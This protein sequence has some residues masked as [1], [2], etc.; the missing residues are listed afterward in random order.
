MRGLHIESATHP[1]KA[2][3]YQIT[4]SFSSKWSHLIKNAANLLLQGI[5]SIKQ[6]LEITG[7]TVSFIC[8]AESSQILTH[9]A[10]TE[11]VADVLSLFATP[12][13]RTTTVSGDAITK[14]GTVV[15]ALFY[16]IELSPV[17]THPALTEQVADLHS[18]FA[19][20]CVRTI[21]PPGDAITKLST[22][23]VTLIYLV[24]FS[25]FLAH[26]A[27][28]E[29][30]AHITSPFDYVCVL[31]IEVFGV[32]ITNLNAVAF[33]IICLLEHAPLLAHHG[34]TGQI[35]DAHSCLVDT[36][37]RNIVGSGSVIAKLSTGVTKAFW[38]PSRAME[39]LLAPLQINGNHAQLRSQQPLGSALTLMDRR[40]GARYGRALLYSAGARQTDFAPIGDLINIVMRVLL[41]SMQLK[42][43]YQYYFEVRCL[44]RDDMSGEVVRAVSHKVKGPDKPEPVNPSSSEALGNAFVR[45]HIE[46]FEFVGC[47]AHFSVVSNDRLRGV[48]APPSLDNAP[49]APLMQRA[50]HEAASPSISNISSVFLADGICFCI[51]C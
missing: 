18:H 24:E 28:T 11:Q 34:L 37:I 42:A 51:L 9:P 7:V 31:S 26:P 38:L 6:T 12:C 32:A 13:V 45:A 3:T 41:P 15:V 21:K 40:A 33:T 46:P 47:R 19:T 44:L 10:L 36:C 27:L 29:Q 17:L 48:A 43:P 4:S 23:A 49:T 5:S 50:A 30:V 1:I 8:S 2:I 22:V 14:L 35:A 25:P 16:L 39:T 20:T